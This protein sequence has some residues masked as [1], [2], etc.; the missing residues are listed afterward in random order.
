MAT[1]VF[2]KPYRV[3]RKKSVFK[4]RF[5]WLGILVVMI[6]GIT[7]YFVAFSSFFQIKEIRISGNEKV[8]KESLENFIW[9]NISKKMFIF[10]TKSIL[11]VNLQKVEKNLLERFP[12]VS[13]IYLK[14]DL[15]DIIAVNIQERKPLFLLC[16]NSDVCFYLDEEG[17]IFDR[18]R[19]GIP[20]G[21]DETNKAKESLIKIRDE[22]HQEIR[23]GEKVIED[24]LLKNIKEII[25]KLK[26]GAEIF[27]K[28]IILSEK[29]I[30]LKTVQNWE[31]YFNPGG[32]I[33]DQVQNL[34][35]VFK[36]EIPLENRE[37]LEYVDLRFGNRVYYKYRE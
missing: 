1:R 5:F 24:D 19:N 4:N 3:R 14:R 37:N 15:P 17:V 30:V 10:K 13:K 21:V 11:L 9:K 7:V 35:L 6:I 33:L 26:G 18:V 36:E 2:R 29:K 27:T 22:R 25:S 34:T 8:Q 23:L 31:I 20:N 32:N 28:E 16:K 12:E